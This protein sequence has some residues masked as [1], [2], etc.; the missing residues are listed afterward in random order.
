MLRRDIIDSPFI[1]KHWFAKCKPVFSLDTETTSLSWL[2]L[3]IIGFSICDGVQACYVNITPEHK[4]ELLD[5]LEYYLS[6]AKLVIMHNAAFDMMVCKKYDIEFGNN[7]W[8]TLTASHLI[9]E[10]LPENGLKYL[11]ERILGV[12][13]EDI[14]KFTD[15]IPGTTEFAIYGMNDAIWTWQLYQKFRPVIVKENLTHLMEDIEMPFCKVLM[16]L[17]INGILPDVNAAKK[18]I[19]PVQHLYYEIENKLL[20]MFGGKYKIGIMPR[21]RRTWCKP[22]I[23]FNSSDQVIPL[24]EGLGFEIYEKAKK[25]GKSWGKRAKKRLKG[26]HPAIDLLIKF[27]TVEKLLSGFLRKFNTFVELDGRIRPSF[28][29]TVCVTGRLSCSNPNIEQLPKNNTIAN[30]RNLFISPIGSV[31]IVADYSGQELRILGEESQDSNLIKAFKEGKDL[32]QEVADAM[33]LP[34]RDDAKPINFGIPYGKQAYGF[35]QDWGC[36]IKEAQEKLDLY[37]HKYPSIRTRIER[38]HLQ[39]SKHGYVRNMSGRR[40]R[41]PDFKKKHKWAKARCYRQA[42]NFIIQS[43]GADTIKV[44]CANIIKDTMLKIINIIHD[45]I[46]CECP[47]DYV[48]QGVGYIKHCMINAIP[49]SIPWEV[50]VGIANRY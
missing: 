36:S 17:Q 12:P 18:M 40:R 5:I 32:H 45:E 49:I 33:G 19:V 9:Q 8:D 30:I 6:E 10:T 26:E 41:F 2:D 42:F 20:E 43:Y 39:V 31:F 24:I 44:A 23:N 46:V 15:V 37:F 14:K 47:I 4:Q 25:G 34:S 29:N 48:E 38:C 50:T 22:S 1:L 21:A 7:I 28:N 35:S 11:A 3:E 16:E 13:K 27:G